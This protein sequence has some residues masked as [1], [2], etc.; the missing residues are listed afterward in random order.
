MCGSLGLEFSHI[1][2]SV[3]DL[4]LVE[5]ACTEMRSLWRKNSDALDAKEVQ[6]TIVIEERIDWVGRDVSEMKRS[7]LSRVFK[8]PATRCLNF[9]EHG[10]AMTGKVAAGEAVWNCAVGCVWAISIP[11]HMH[12]DT[13]LGWGSETRALGQKGP[14]VPSSAALFCREGHRQRICWLLGLTRPGCVA[15]RPKSDPMPPACI[16][17]DPAYRQNCHSLHYTA[18]FQVD[19]SIW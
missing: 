19:D 12:C 17:D 9:G 7:F 4:W 11:S 2:M 8:W 5:L 1:P 3:P 14:E 13:S 6:D 10:L 15:P 18:T 16:I